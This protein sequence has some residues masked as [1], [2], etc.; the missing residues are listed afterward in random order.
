MI[1]TFSNRKSGVGKSSLCLALANYWASNNIPVKV[2][3][4]DPQQSLCKTRKRDLEVYNIKPQYDILKYNLSEQLDEFSKHV[5][6]LKKS[7]EF[8]LFDTPAGINSDIF[9]YLIMFS[10]YVI[11]PFKFETY[12]IDA[13]GRYSM[14]LRMLEKLYPLQQ[15]SVIY[16]PNMVDTKSE[17]Y[18]LYNNTSG[19]DLKMGTYFENK[20]PNI[21]LHNCMQIRNSLFLAPEAL[22]CVSS[23]FE[24]LTKVILHRL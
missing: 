7:E 6:E 17:N 1:I 3:D 14:A 23:C 2:I 4:V 16:I 10:D 9:M 18:S 12:S 19:C 24:Y 20:S 21:P 22:T 11:V 8:I 15:R 5:D 13:T